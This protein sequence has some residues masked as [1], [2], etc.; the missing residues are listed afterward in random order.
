MILVSSVCIFYFSF[1]QHSAEFLPLGFSLM[2]QPMNPSVPL[3]VSEYSQKKVCE[4]VL[5]RWLLQE[6]RSE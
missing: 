6:A 2:V 3:P 1:D 4:S 5:Q